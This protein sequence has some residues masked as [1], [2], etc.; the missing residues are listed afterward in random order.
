MPRTIVLFALI[1]TLMTGLVLGQMS[2]LF[3]KPVLIAATSDSA[4]AETART[5]YRAINLYLGT[6]DAQTL[7]QLLAPGFVGHVPHVDGVE[8]AQAFLQYLESLRST[9]PGLQLEVRD[10]SA[11]A[12]TVAVDIKL[13]GDTI[14]AFTGLPLDAGAGVSGYEV[15]RVEGQQIAERWGSRE[16]PPSF[17]LAFAGEMPVNADIFSEPRIERLELKPNGVLELID[18]GG[19]LLIAESLGLTYEVVSLPYPANTSKSPFARSSSDFPVPDEGMSVAAAPGEAAAF[20]AGVRLQMLN[21]GSEV[22]HALVVSVRQAQ[23]SM[24]GELPY[25]VLESI[26]A[27]RSLMAGGGV[28][29]TSLP[30]STRLISVGAI[31]LPPGAVIPRHV[32]VDAELLVVADGQIEV[33]VDQGT[34]VWSQP[35]KSFTVVRD[36]QTIGAGDAARANPGTVVEYRTGREE[37]ATLWIVTIGESP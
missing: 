5:F 35:G 10:L 17:R 22:V 9:F 24:G 23:L 18:Y 36:V 14:G 11:Q 29:P 28:V 27:E 20:P 34:M 2:S 37:P 30:D 31:V 3:Q 7:E 19:F 13:T 4:A 21:T 26:G 6:G 15:L 8:S 16:M 25:K 1:L 12:G 33:A 32:T